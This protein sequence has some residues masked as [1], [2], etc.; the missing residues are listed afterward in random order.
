MAKAWILGVA[1]ALTLSACTEN[2]SDSGTDAPLT[3]L[4]DLLK[5]GSATD[6][7][8]WEAAPLESHRGF[9]CERPDGY[10]FIAEI[11]QDG[12]I[13]SAVMVLQGAIPVERTRGLIS[14]NA[15]T[16]RLQET[17]FISLEARTYSVVGGLAATPLWNGSGERSARDNGCCV[18]SGLSDRTFVVQVANEL[19]AVFPSIPVFLAG[20]SNGGML[21][22][23]LMYNESLEID[24]YFIAMASDQTT[25][26][27]NEH[28][29]ASISLIAVRDD[30][31][32]PFA[33][34]PIALSFALGTI[35]AENPFVTAPA[36]METLSDLKQIM[37]CAPD[38]P[39]RMSEL[40]QGTIADYACS[41]GALTTFVLEQG[42]HRLGSPSLLAR[43]PQ[44][45]DVIGY[46]LQRID[47]Q[48]A[49]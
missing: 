43:T 40:G 8:P 13:T 12:I 4:S 36:F 10:R 26:R 48:L 29:E 49:E 16:E 19:R 22:I 2:D 31:V 44:R 37:G 15:P 5:Y 3:G 24:H 45:Q 17:L 14:N 23:D 47:E 18:N 41:E 1:L 28:I 27:L 20:F 21:A 38:A 6:C 9:V 46:L 25:E 35:N 7:V 33:G 32:I 11:P 34:G 39:V 30:D 42:G